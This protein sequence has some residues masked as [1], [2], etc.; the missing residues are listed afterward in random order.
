MSLWG[1]ALDAE[2]EYRYERARRSWGTRRTKD[3][4]RRTGTVCGSV[5]RRAER[6]RRGIEGMRPGHV[7]H[8]RR[9]RP[10]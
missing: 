3:A 6:L 2:V 5:A 1:P 10:A 8:G 9:G 7:V 4:S